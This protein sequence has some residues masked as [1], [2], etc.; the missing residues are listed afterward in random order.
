MKLSSQHYRKSSPKKSSSQG[1][2][3]GDGVR[4][5]I[6]PHLSSSWPVTWSG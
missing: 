1:T 4:C 2:Q 5:F 6:P 3:K